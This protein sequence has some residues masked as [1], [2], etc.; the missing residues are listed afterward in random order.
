MQTVQRSCPAGTALARSVYEH[1]RTVS[2][3]TVD[4]FPL[5]Q[6]GRTVLLQQ[7]SAI[8]YYCIVAGNQHECRAEGAGAGEGDCGGKAHPQ[9]GRDLE[10]ADAAKGLGCALHFL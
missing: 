10:L 9:F 8:N 2:A 6:G 7:V 4:A 3:S 5:S 1:A